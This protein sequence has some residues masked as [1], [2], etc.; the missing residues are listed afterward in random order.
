HPSG[1]ARLPATQAMRQTARLAW[2]PSLLRSPTRRIV[3]ALES[4]G[5]AGR[6]ASAERSL[7]WSNAVPCLPLHAGS[8]LNALGRYSIVSYTV[9]C[10]PQ[11][12]LRAFR[13]Q[14]DMIP[15]GQNWRQDAELS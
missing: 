4:S 9:N 13:A 14:F 1:S 15:N 7:S 8:D 6:W 11:A 12:G 2:S 10:I 3:L 5:R